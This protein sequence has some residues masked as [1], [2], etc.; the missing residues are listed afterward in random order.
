V[1]LNLPRVEPKG[2]L[3]DVSAKMPNRK[4]ETTQVAHVK[5]IFACSDTDVL[6][7]FAFRALRTIFPKSLLKIFTRRCFIGKLLEELKSAYRAS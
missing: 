4:L 7:T 6:R 2:K 3:I 5:S 1:P